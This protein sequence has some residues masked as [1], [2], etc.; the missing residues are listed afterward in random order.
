MLQA[1]GLDM[2]AEA[3]Y[4][5]MLVRHD[6]DAEQIGRQAGISGERVVAALDKLAALGLLRRSLESP[7]R[8][9]PVLPGL[10]FQL[11]LQ[12]QQAELL[13]RQKEF[14]DVQVAI[15]RL[16]VEYSALCCTGGRNGL[17]HIENL[18]RIQARLEALADQSTSECLS[19]MPDRVQ[20]ARS[21]EVNRSLDAYM[22]RRGVKVSTVYLDS[23]RNDRSSFSQAR[24][25]TENGG[26]VR[27]VP[28][29]PVRMVI[30]DRKVAVVPV[31]PGATRQGAAQIT[32]T[33][34]LA[35]LL[36]LFEMVW[37][38]GTPLGHEQPPAEQGS[39]TAQEREILRLLAQGLTDDVVGKR[40]G[41]GLRT[42]RR[43]MADISKRL[44]ARSRFE[45]GAKAS[46]RGWLKP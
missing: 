2:E 15:S 42:V 10:A 36:A 41:L 29:L 1:L 46:E 27:T 32:G 30:F 31:D 40:L 44:G 45:V 26:A 9:A 11:W 43:N 8:L 37:E 38:R 16:T 25:L 22:L 23:V 21:L 12:Q 20:S 39:V 4:R 34:V 6:W 5:I 18:D 19:F 35:G 13:A 24:W 17:E 14:V 3:V 33:G 7:A 28:S